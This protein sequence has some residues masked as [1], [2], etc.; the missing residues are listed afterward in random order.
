MLWEPAE[1]KAR[2]TLLCPILQHQLLLPLRIS[3][4]CPCASPV[5]LQFPHSVHHEG[6]ASPD[7]KLGVF[8][9]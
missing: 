8:W 4:S 9:G 6:S 3:L 7:A 1:L 5:L 2:E